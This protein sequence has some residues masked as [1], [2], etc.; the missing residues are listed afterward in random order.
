MES[1]PEGVEYAP[2]SPVFLTTFEAWQTLIGIATT[3]IN[4]GSFYWS[5]KSDEVFNHTSSWQGQQIFQQLLAA[6][7]D[8][9]IQIQIA[10]S[11]PTQ[12]KKIKNIKK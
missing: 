7:V 8:R 11:V 3:K 4:I 5:L 10:Q 9:N 2:G 6:G 1:I 12:V